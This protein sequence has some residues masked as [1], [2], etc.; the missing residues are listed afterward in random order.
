M[1]LIDEIV[2]KPGEWLRGEGPMGDVVIS[3]RMRLAR[4]IEGYPFLS[5][6]T[7]QQRRDLA[8]MLRKEIDGAATAG[9]WTYFDME[10]LSD[11]DQHV[12][13]ERHLISRHHAET[14]GCRGV[15]ISR[16]EIVSVMVNEED[17]LRMQVVRSGLMLREMWDQVSEIDDRLE[18]HVPFA[19]H[20]RYGYLTA[21]PT[22]L[23]TGIRF[24]VMLHLPA[25]KLTGELE[26]VFRAAKDMRLAVRGLYGEGTE[27]NG[28]FFQVSNQVTLGKTEEEII[29]DFKDIVIPKI[30]QYEEQARQT[31]VRER[32]IALDDRIW[33]SYG[34]LCNART[35]S[36]EETMAHLSHLRLGVHL[37]RLKTI[38]LRKINELFILAQPAHLQKM[39]GARM[40]GEQRSAA[41]AEQIRKQ[42]GETSG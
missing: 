8:T 22:N 33:R 4:N 38:D 17:H 5:K 6:A 21:C 41:R 3:S 9:S 25:L 28:D 30:I 42:L 27:A 29:D 26:K 18:S 36:S 16:D 20:S 10:E 32:P 23:G 35:I 15:S 24:S 31:L 37:G 14:T 40:S 34:V 12:L 13:V 2:K 39:Y 1:T 11:L 19:F 7:E